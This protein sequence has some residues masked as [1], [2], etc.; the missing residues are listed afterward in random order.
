MYNKKIEDVLNELSTRQD[1]LT[2][3]EISKRNQKKNELEKPKKESV[4]LKFIKELK[5]PL[6][7]I[8]IIAAVISLI[9]SPSDWIESIIIVIV[10]LINATLGVFQENKAEKSL[11]ALQ[12]LTT[13]KTRVR[14]NGEVMVID[15]VDVVVGDILILEAGDF[16]SADARI[17]KCTNLKVDESA[18]TGES[19]PVNKKSSVIEEDNLA[20]ADQKN[21][22]FTS[23]YITDGNAEAV[24]TE[25]GMDT[26]I[27]KLANILNETTKQKTPLQIRLEE[28]GKVIGILSIAICI[29]VFL[30]ELFT[31]RVDGKF[32]V[33]ESFK[34]AVALAV[35]AVPEGLATV[36]TITLAIGV[37]KMAKQN[38]IIKKMP[39]VETL[40]SANII[41]SDKTG[42]LTINKMTVKRIYNGE[43]KTTDELTEKDYDLVKYFATCCTAKETQKGYIG[44]PTEI[45]LL[46]LN[47][48]VN[49][50]Y[51]YPQI[52]KELPFD[53]D[54]KMMSVLIEDGNRYLQITK[55][56]PDIVLKRSLS[57]N[58]QIKE[59]TKA[60]DQMADDALR[61]L[62]LGIR[63]YD[64]IPSEL[65]ENNLTFIGLVGMIDPPRTEVKAAILKAKQAG[66]VT[67]M[68]T[69]DQLP[70]AVAIGKELNILN[71]KSEAIS[72]NELA[73]LSDE[74]L[75]NQIE[76]Y[77]V[78]ARVSPLDK[79]RI[80]KA[81]QKKD[82]VVA[83]TGDGVND[84]PALKCADIGCAMEITGTDV[85]KQAADMVLV[86]DNYTTI[87]SAIEE[88]RNIYHNIKNVISYL[89]SSNIGEICTILFA[90]II[91]I[92][93][94]ELGV[95]LSPIHLLWINLI[96][97]TLPSIG[98]GMEKS[99]K[100][101]MNQPPR[102]KNENIFQKEL[103]VKILFEG[104]LI[105]TITLIAYLLGER[106]DHMTGQ[107]MAFLTLSTC[108]LFH[109][110][111]VKTDKRIFSKNILNNKT[112]NISFIVGFLMQII[113]IYVP[114]V[115]SNIFKLSPL[116]LSNLMICIGL[117]LAVIII[118]NILSLFKNKHKSNNLQ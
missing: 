118:T 13:P 41:C 58:E 52:I 80:V 24:V 66:L 86:D 85:A 8:L 1:G 31:T 57:T 101:I 47:K 107:T 87:I 114:N 7:I 76:K 44:D 92:F 115:N 17:I 93:G 21:M 35:A 48:K 34:T 30:L 90:S 40:G 106:V 33:L 6:V 95:P 100:D 75:S 29:V 32:Y 22:L 54:R 3:E 56:A 68:I 14:R 94:K 113:V 10:V 112:L 70:T 77:K 82:M 65:E 83:M 61:V 60:N 2:T 45:A 79:V 27:G 63:Y 104:I 105:G 12:K 110:Y 102:S 15:S 23:T 43:M 53:S 96:T 81:W 42:T 51:I 99:S 108:Q 91:C 62:G 11:E 69:G 38:A 4:V 16:I 111:N 37:N 39:A 28:V 46:E 84:A 89:L 19:L 117:A 9:T 116:D 78:Y 72:S 109:A 18:L 64:E 59:I 98:L 97:D 25:I 73:K 55:G 20:I 50:E 88:G 36:V 74:E 67:I 49:N 26:E 103:M 71:D 5:D